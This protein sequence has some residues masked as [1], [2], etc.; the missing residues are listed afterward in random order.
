M[1]ES[2]HASDRQTLT[3][4]LL[5]LRH[6]T[7]V[8]AVARELCGPAIDREP[9]WPRCPVCHGE[10]D[11]FYKCQG[12]IVGCDNCVDPVDAWDETAEEWV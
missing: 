10:T 7:M 2:Q 4:A 6:T 1:T 3:D 12:E 8:C 9:R 11:T 5:R